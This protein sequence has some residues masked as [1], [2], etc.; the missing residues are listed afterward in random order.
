MPVTRKESGADGVAAV[1]GSYARG[2]PDVPQLKR[3]CGRTSIDLSLHLI[4]SLTVGDRCKEIVV[5]AQTE[6]ADVCPVARNIKRVLARRL[7]YVSFGFRGWWD[8][9]HFKGVRSQCNE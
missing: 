9:V 1:K 2:S 7:R 8:G 4:C 3:T 6:S 5:G